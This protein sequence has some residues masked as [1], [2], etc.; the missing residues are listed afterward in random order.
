MNLHELKVPELKARAKALS[1]EGAD[2][3]K[4]S[5]LL[6]A[7]EKSLPKVNLIGIDQAKGPDISV[8]FEKTF[9]EEKPSSKNN[10]LQTHPKFA[11]FN[12]GE[13]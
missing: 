9:S 7:I 8:T 5:E 4:K 2:S 6:E 11:K 10:D 12:T 13:N 1:I 3:M